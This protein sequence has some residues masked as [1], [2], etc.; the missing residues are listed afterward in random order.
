[1]MGYKTK[2]I[3]VRI[4]NHIMEKMG[5]DQPRTQIIIKALNQYYRSKEPNKELFTETQL[6]DTQIKSLEKDISYL[7]Q[8]NEI[9]T[10]YL[11]DQIEDWKKISVINMGFFKSIKYR[12]TS[13]KEKEDPQTTVHQ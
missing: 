10:T 12:L 1:M 8:Q 3:S 7:K 5:D 6:Y 2:Q 13:R 11:K 9:Q 4:P